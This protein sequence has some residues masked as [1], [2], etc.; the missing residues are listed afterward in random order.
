MGKKW[1]AASEHRHNGRRPTLSTRLVTLRYIKEITSS[2]GDCR[3]VPLQQIAE[4]LVEAGHKSLDDQA[5]ALGIHRSTAWTI[6]KTKHKLGRLNA[7]TTQ[8][9]LENPDTPSAVRSVVQ[10]YLSER[11]DALAVRAQRLN[12]GEQQSN[13]LR[14]V[15]N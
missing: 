3:T 14:A 15:R 6:V 7:K 9:I 8:R 2:S 11:S 5:R 1:L 10:N 12:R 13:K 4:A